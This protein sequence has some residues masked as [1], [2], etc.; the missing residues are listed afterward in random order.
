VRREPL[1]ALRE[2]ALRD[3]GELPP[4]LRRLRQPPPEPYP[5][6]LSAR[7]SQLAGDREPTAST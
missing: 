4:A 6:A 2:R 3:L 7:L 1:E 5:V